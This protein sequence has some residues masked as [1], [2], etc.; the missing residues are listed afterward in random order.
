[1]LLTHLQLNRDPE[2]TVAT[3]RAAYAGPVSLVSD[4]DRVTIPG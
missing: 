4:G 1:V 2:A 3:V